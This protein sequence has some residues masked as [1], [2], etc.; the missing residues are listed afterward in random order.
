MKKYLLTIIVIAA[1][2]P[3]LLAQNRITTNVRS[4]QNMNDVLSNSRFLFSEF[5]DALVLS[6]KGTG[7]AKM[8]YDMFAGAMMFIDPNGDTLAVLNPGEIRAIRFGRQ[9]FIHTA[10]EYVEVLATAGVVSLTVSRR[11][12]PATVKQYGAYGMTTSSAAIDNLS[13]MTDKTT[14]DGLTINKEITYAVIQLFYLHDGKSLRP[15]T[16]K[17]FQKLF[18]K[19]K[20]VVNAYVKEQDLDLKKEEDVI[21]LFNFCAQDKE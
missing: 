21:R 5:Q 14:P 19:S 18:N 12:K 11:I 20:E 13:V 10:K 16:E 1:S 6:K 3:A 8:N 9:E 15:A 7:K 4:G 2:Y 17:N